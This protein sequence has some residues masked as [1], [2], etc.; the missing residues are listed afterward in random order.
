MV[1]TAARMDY[2]MYCCKGW[3]MVCTAAMDRLWSVLLQGIY[4]G[5]YCC[6]DGLWYVLLQGWT[7]VCTAA[8]MDYGLYCY[9]GFQ[10]FPNYNNLKKC[11]CFCCCQNEE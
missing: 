6:K 9:K 2:G 4:Y 8:R 10:Q 3:T 7:M 11:C 5:L 1:C